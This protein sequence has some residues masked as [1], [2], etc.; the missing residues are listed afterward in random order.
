MTDQQPHSSETVCITVFGVGG[1]G[2]NAVAHLLQ[3]PDCGMRIV[4]ANTDVQALQNV[5][6]A[7]RLQLGRHVTAGLGAG[8]RPD[9]GRAAAEE[10]LPEIERALDG[11]ALCFIAAGLGG[12]TGTGAAPVIARAA[13]A[14]GILTIGVATKPF[15]FEG[16]RR[17]RTAETGAALLAAQVDVMVTVCNQKLFE[18]IGPTTTLRAALDLSDA[19]IGES[20]TDFALLLGEPALKR[21]GV[22]DLRAILASSGNAV[23]GY[24]ESHAGAD[25][26]TEAARSA[27]CNPLLEGVPG[28]A[29][30][31][32]VTVAGGADLGLFEVE[33]AISHVRGGMGADTE[34][35]WG[36]TIDRALDGLLRVGIVAA[37][38]PLP[39]PAAA[40]A[41]AYVLPV[42]PAP[43]AT[44]APVAAPAIRQLALPLERA[45]SPLPSSD[46]V[47]RLAIV[48]RS[49]VTPSLV[50]RL[51]GVARQAKRRWQ[52]RPGIGKAP[53]AAM[54]FNVLKTFDPPARVSIP[55]IGARGLITFK[56]ALAE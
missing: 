20:A 9:I 3:R 1:A 17:T 18:V 5:P 45:N 23:I 22:A 10:A 50:D 41:A 32:L 19:I 36:A 55:P 15:A 51:H 29:R 8:A 11:A 31:L 21:I 4:C 37:G 13:R 49:A 14:R 38:L 34:L 40:Q 39:A 44:V 42:A 2:G 28:T 46:D 54:V 52:G 27:L 47:A 35:V 33:E 53:A 12:G 26:A 25:R 6:Q 43:R 7:N 56:A 16:K 24:G 30:R 48:T